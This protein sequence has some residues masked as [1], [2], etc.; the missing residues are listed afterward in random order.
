MLLERHLRCVPGCPR[1]FGS[2]QILLV[3]VR[4]I[5]K[6]S[7]EKGVNII[8]VVV[9]ASMAHATMDSEFFRYPPDLG[10]MRKCR[11]RCLYMQSLC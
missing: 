9:Q 10:C 2:P 3:V 8:R 11:L 7:E 1:I 4:D 6:Q 5:G